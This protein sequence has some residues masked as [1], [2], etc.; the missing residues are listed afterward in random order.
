MVFLMFDVIGEYLRRRIIERLLQGLS[1]VLMVV[2]I[3]RK[4]IVII[5]SRRYDK[6]RGDETRRDVIDKETLQFIFTNAILI[7]S[8]T[9]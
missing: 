2:H 8:S 5:V 4:A 1:I 6:A 3:K 7:S 9:C